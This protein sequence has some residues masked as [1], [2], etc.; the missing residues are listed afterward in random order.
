MLCIQSSMTGGGIGV[1]TVFVATSPTIRKASFKASYIRRVSSRRV[2]ISRD[3]DI[4][5]CYE[6]MAMVFIN[7]FLHVEWPYKLKELI[8][9]NRS[10]LYGK[11]YNVS[12]LIKIW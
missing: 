4:R 11:T 1:D 5:T 12:S 8:L 9:L 2:C 6:R 3:S 7:I 10:K